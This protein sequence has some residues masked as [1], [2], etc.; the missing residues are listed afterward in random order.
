VGLVS[1]GV[2]RFSIRRPIKGLQLEPQLRTQVGDIATFGMND[3]F[4]AREPVTVRITRIGGDLARHPDLEWTM[5][6]GKLVDSEDEV[7]LLVRVAALLPG[8]EQPKRRPRTA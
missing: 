2:H 3:C 7:R 8:D 5:L 4:N 1:H 6:W